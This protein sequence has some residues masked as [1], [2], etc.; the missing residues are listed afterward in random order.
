MDL[1]RNTLNIDK[2]DIFLPYSSETHQGR[3]ELWEIIE[4]SF[5]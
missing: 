3:E 2:N 1:I 4:Q 5:K